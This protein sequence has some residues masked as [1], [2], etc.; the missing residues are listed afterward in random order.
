[1]TKVVILASNQLVSGSYLELVMLNFQNATVDDVVPYLIL[2]L[3]P[4]TVTSVTAGWH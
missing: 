1:M 4:S 2:G 3:L